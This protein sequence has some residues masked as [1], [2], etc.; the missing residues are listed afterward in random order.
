M[1]VHLP[2]GFGSILRQFIYVISF[3]QSQKLATKSSSIN[4]TLKVFSQVKISNLLMV[5]VMKNHHI[6]S[7]HKT[8]CLCLEHVEKMKLIDRLQPQQKSSSL[9]CMNIFAK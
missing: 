7:T 5:L 6:N 8:V 2:I 3:L 4:K 1:D 9:F